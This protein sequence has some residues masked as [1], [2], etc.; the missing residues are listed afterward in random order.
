MKINLIKNYSLFAYLKSIFLIWL[1]F[2]FFFFLFRTVLKVLAQYY[3]LN[4][5]KL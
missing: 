4:S 5:I 3:S 2:I 1:N